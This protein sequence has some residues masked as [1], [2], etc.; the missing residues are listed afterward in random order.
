MSWNLVGAVST[1]AAASLETLLTYE[2]AVR[3]AAQLQL[4]RSIYEAL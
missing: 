1:A 4:H 3:T 2:P